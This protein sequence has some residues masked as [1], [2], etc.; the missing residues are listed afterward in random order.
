[1]QDSMG[2]QGNSFQNAADVLGNM[3]AEVPTWANVEI[4]EIWPRSCQPSPTNPCHGRHPAPFDRIKKQMANEAG[5]LGR[6]QSATL[7]VW[8]W[9]SCFSPNAIGDPH[10]PFP[11]AA[12]ANYVAY[13]EYLNASLPNF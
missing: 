10:H 4:F 3:S 13:L 8:E 6:P 2:A 5:K 1:M 11:E 9:Y 12:K 7:I